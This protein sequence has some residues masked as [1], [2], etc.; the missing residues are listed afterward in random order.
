MRPRVTMVLAIVAV[1]IGGGMLVPAAYAKFSSGDGIGG[2]GGGVAQVP[3]PEP[4]APP[5]PTLAAGPVSV[6]FKGKFFSWAL[7]DRKTGKISGTPN[8]ASTNSTESMI[9]AWIVSDYLRQLNGK[10][11]SAERKKQATTAIRDSNDRS[12]EA[13]YNAGGRKPVLDRL[14][15]MCKLTD[16][17]I[18]PKARWA[19]TQMSPRDAVRM[20]DCIG[21]G[22]AA[23]PKWTKWVLTEMANVRGGVKDQ[24]SVEVQGGH[25]G[26]VDGLP[27]S[28]TSQGPVSI[29]N[30][31]TMLWADGQ[32]HVNCLAVADDWT[33]A[34]MMRY[35]GAGDTR[36]PSYGAKVCASV[37]TQLVTPQPGAALKVPQQPVGKL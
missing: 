19:Y 7:M 22:T 5:K 36:T 13:L 16:T 21:D 15:K 33:L 14:I 34:V 4:T 18:E 29:K 24:K 27:A 8:M 28:I 11:L 3:T 20:G 26:I 6:N 37:A 35:P 2:I 30:G 17:K 12:A 25:W 31:F 1:L 32:W 23:G 9:K 10:P